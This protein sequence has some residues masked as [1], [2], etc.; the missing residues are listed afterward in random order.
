MK[1]LRYILKLFNP[2]I[3]IWNLLKFAA[4]LENYR[5]SRTY[6]PYDFSNDTQYF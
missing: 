1:Y 2:F 4:H 6:K 3:A 5:F